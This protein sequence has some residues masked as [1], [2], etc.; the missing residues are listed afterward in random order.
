M[1]LNSLT[2]IFSTKLLPLIYA[3]VGFGLLITIHEFGHFIFCKIFNI[4]TPT[5]SIGMGPKIIERKIG[6]TNFRLSAIPLGGYVEVAG[7]SEVGQGKQESAKLEGNNSFKNKSYWQKALVLCGGVIFNLLFAYII[8]SILFF[9][10]IPKKRAEFVVSNKIEKTIQ[11]KFKLMPNDKIISINNEKLNFESKKLLSTLKEKIIIP[12]TKKSHAYIKL[13]ILRNNKSINLK[14]I[15]SNNKN[16]NNKFINSFKLKFKEI[17]DQYEKY[18]FFQAIA[19]GI[20][21]TNEWIVQMFKGIGY[22]IK[23]HSL[24]GAG[25]PIMILSKTFETAQKG[26]IPL[27]KFLAFIS[28]NLAIINI[29]PIGALDGGQ[30]LFTT[31]EAI[32]RRKIP[33]I[34]KLTINVASW[35]LLLSLIF[36][37][38]FKD[39]VAIIYKKI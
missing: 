26:L 38:S 39:L 2:I 7:L 15:P 30:L 8:Y 22:L 25:G 1:S 37:L 17:K 19:K 23:S 3:I 16:I 11:K 36:Y 32:I 28:I 33:E 20:Q 21:I 9:I 10:G 31:I 6:T 4:Y 35:I 14:I 5:F 29:L 27:L 13:G 34:I 12:F 24:K 18:P